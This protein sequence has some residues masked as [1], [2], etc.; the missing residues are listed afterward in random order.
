MEID[1]YWHKTHDQFNLLLLPIVLLFDFFLFYDWCSFKL[2]IYLIIFSIYVIIDGLWIFFIPN[3]VAS[4]NTILVHHIVT[5]IGIILN[6]IMGLDYAI[7]GAFGGLVEV[8]T[9]FLIARRNWKSSILLNFMFF[10]SWIVIRNIIG[11]WVLYVSIQILLQK[12]KSMKTY[13]IIIGI[14]LTL[15]A[16]FLNLLNVKWTWDLFKK[17]FK[18][19]TSSSSEDSKGL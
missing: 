9:F 10:L 1:P 3:S 16:L 15:I 7:L 19:A 13:K 6:L 18:K 2:Q 8:N 12:Y 11:P 4:P 14:I 5:L 17:Q